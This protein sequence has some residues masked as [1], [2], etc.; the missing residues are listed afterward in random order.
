M[1]IN[2][3]I[4]KKEL[5]N[6]LF[7]LFYKEKLAGS[8]VDFFFYNHGII[9]ITFWKNNKIESYIW[10]DMGDIKNV[11]KIIKKWENKGVNEVRVIRRIK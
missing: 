6:K 8:D 3:Q 10:I 11:R 2:N 5:V 4:K 9:D 7:E 1:K